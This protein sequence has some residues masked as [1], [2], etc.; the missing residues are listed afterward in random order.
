M[1]VVYWKRPAF[2]HAAVRVVVPHIEV[3]S[4]KFIVHASLVYGLIL[5]TVH[6]IAV[7][8]CVIEVIYFPLSYVSSTWDTTG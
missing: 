6:W 7:R 3:V 8:H 4:L 5:R 1:T 2:V